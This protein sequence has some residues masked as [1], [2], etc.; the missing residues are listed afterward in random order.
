MKSENIKTVEIRDRCKF[1][2][3]FAIRML[4]SDEFELFLF[5]QAGYGLFN[6]CIMLISIEEPWLSNR[7]SDEWINSPRTMP[8]AHKWIED[9]F[10]KINNGDVIDIEFILGEKDAKSL[11]S[12]IEQKMEEFKLMTGTNVE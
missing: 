7:S 9:N 10:D 4:P 11:N 12:F 2:P 1:I 3:A 5:K 6:P 8:I